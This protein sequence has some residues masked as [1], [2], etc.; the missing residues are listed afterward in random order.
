MVGIREYWLMITTG[1]VLLL[2]AA[3]LII[4]RPV[5]QNLMQETSKQAGFVLSNLTIS[6]TERTERNAVLALLDIEAGIPLMAIDLNV[7]QT[8]IEILPWVRRATVTRILPGDININIEERVPFALWQRDGKLRLIDGSGVVITQHGLASFADLL[9]IVGED[10]PAHISSLQKTL[11][12]APALAGQIKTVVRVGERR[13]D[14][15]FESGVRV[16]LP[17]DSDL[18]YTSGAAWKRF[19]RLETK[20]RLLAREV[21][22]IDMRI[23]DRLIMRVTPAGRR[24]MDG[25]EWAT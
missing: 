9:M 4:G 21:S 15:V 2:A 12:L 20:H 23:A 17:D 14:I 19:A 1:L 3:V 16:K 25:K 6:G 8:R 24:M 11:S 22:V 7:L 10:A 13:W 18:A 5:V